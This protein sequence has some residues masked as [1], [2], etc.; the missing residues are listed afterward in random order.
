MNVSLNDAKMWATPKTC[1]P[2][3]TV[4][5]RVTFSSFTSLVFLLDCS[6][7]PTKP[8]RIKTRKRNKLSK[9]SNSIRESTLE[10]RLDAWRFHVTGYSYNPDPRHFE[11]MRKNPSFPTNRD[12]KGNAI[13][14]LGFGSSQ[15]RGITRKTKIR[16]RVNPPQA[17]FPKP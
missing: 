16:T 14:F 11:K 1:S 15:F 8:N 5:P 3:R 9:E 4:G 10:T 12:G 17:A 13:F 7:K 6:A 2:S